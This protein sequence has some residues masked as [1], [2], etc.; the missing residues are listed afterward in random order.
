VTDFT[1]GTQAYAQHV[2]RYSDALGRAMVER[3][4]L[5]GGDRAL[6]VGCGPGPLLAVL[7][8]RLGADHVSGVEPSPPFA[9]MARQRVPGADVRIGS[10]ERLPFPDASF[11]AVL[12]QL[13]VNFMTDAARGVGEM[14]RVARRAVASC[15]WDYREAMTMLRVFWDAALEVDPDAPDEGRTMRWATP[16]ELESLWSGARLR[17]VEVD[18][19]VVAARYEGFDDYWAPFPAG[20]GPSGAYCASLPPPRQEALREACR[21]RL[22][23]PNGPFELTARAWVAIGQIG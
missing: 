19:L 10:A 6:D 9:D 8:E 20:I 3:V 21:R 17:S 23:N 13:V 7:A 5:E 15:V 14:A 11:D 16:S 2:G 1:T 4:G 22:G 12:S 18:S